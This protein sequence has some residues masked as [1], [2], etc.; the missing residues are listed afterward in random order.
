MVSRVSGLH[1]FVLQVQGPVLV[2]DTCLCFNA[3]GGLPGPYIKW[4]LEKLK[5]EGINL[6]R[7]FHGSVGDENLHL[8]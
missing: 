1:V 3:L 8:V 6:L 5:P 2:E 4:F 7:F